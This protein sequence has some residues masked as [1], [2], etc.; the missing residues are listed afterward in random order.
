M[1]SKKIGPTQNKNNK[2]YWGKPGKLFYIYF[3]NH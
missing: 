3:S 2:I 1:T